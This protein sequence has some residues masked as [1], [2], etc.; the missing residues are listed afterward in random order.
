[1]RETI[2]QLRLELRRLVSESLGAD[3]VLRLAGAATVNGGLP[4][5]VRPEHLQALRQTITEAANA[6]AARTGEMT[7]GSYLSG[8]LVAAA[9][10]AEP[11]V[12]TAT[13]LQAEV[14]QLAVCLTMLADG[15]AAFATLAEAEQVRV[16][17]GVALELLVSDVR[18]AALLLVTAQVQLAARLAKA[19]APGGPEAA[20]R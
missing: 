15:L 8:F 14:M 7:A 19:A 17:P 5:P 4:P 3:D 1:M 9:V 2:E 10:P 13:D 12:M 11:G 18:T 20:S 6:L 16:L